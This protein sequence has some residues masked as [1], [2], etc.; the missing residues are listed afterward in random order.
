MTM[1]RR[2]AGNPAAGAWMAGH[3][4][5]ALAA[6]ATG[7]A[8][9][10]PAA[11]PAAASL[12]QPGEDTVFSCP[13]GRKQIAVCASPGLGATGG[14]LQYRF[15]R[16]GAVELQYP[17]ADG[18]TADWRASVRAGSLMFSGGGGAWLALDK[19]DH[20]YVVYTAIGRG[21]GTKEGVVVERA[22]R[23]IAHVPC[24]QAAQSQLGPDLA[25]RAGIAPDTR[26]FDLP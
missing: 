1:M 17:P 22:G 5:A 21:W 14:Q 9:A 4:V 25:S 8:A 7:S 20:R 23:R 2:Q 24:T 18:S 16:P 3:L 10:T 26:E 11:T 6:L 13:A 12:C 15:G 19:G